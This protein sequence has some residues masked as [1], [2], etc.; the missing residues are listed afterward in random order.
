MDDQY[1]VEIMDTSKTMHY[2]III[3]IFC[4]LF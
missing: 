4:I 2:K 1:L 3:I